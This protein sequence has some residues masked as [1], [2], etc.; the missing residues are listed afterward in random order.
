MRW[1][2][3]VWPAALV[4]SFCNVESVRAADEGQE[5]PAA[6]QFQIRAREVTAQYVAKNQAGEA[7][8]RHEQP[9]L[10]WSNPV[11]GQQ[12]LGEVYLWTDQE[13]PAAVLSLYELTRDSG[14]VVEHHEWALLDPRG[15]SFAGPA[16]WEPKPGMTELNPIP[17]SAPPGESQ[18]ARLGQMRRLAAAF[19]GQKTTRS[20]EVRTLRLL[21]QP[22]YQ[23][24][25]DG[26][27][28]GLFAFVEATDPELFL[29][30]ETNQSGWSYSAM[31]MSNVRLVLTHQGKA[32]WDAPQLTWSEAVGRSDLPYSAFRVR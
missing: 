25:Q 3:T 5:T 14:G 32:V 18:R 7:L 2:L 30:L 12:A 9:L 23:Y 27:A 6:R 22:L 8:K 26:T 24:E 28:G 4:L 16:R 19:A 13:R 29:L 1:F 31:R 10:R 11:D 15:V 17:G 21:S 20:G